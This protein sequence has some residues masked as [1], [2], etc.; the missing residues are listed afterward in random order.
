MFMFESPAMDVLDVQRELAALRAELAEIRRADSEEW[1]DRARAEHVQSIVRDVLADS[2]TRQ[3][4]SGQ[5]WRSDYS[6][7]L[8]VASDDGNW[9]MTFGVTQQV[10]FV[11]SSAYGDE[12]ST[13]DV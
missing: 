12:S 2:S 11:Y 4:Q 3:D 1:M 8:S 13:D 9:T 7:G 10:K 6:A 5:R